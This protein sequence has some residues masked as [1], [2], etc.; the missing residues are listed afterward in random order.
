MNSKKASRIHVFGF[1]FLCH[2]NLKKFG[3][4]IGLGGGVDIRFFGGLK[5]GFS[6]SEIGF[7]E[8]SKIR[9]SKV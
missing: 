9:F 7:W 8:G 1:F 2:L 4:E 5:K 3:F 6:R